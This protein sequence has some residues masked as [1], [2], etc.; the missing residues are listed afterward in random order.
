MYRII[1]NTDGVLFKI[2][3][4]N[5]D[6]VREL[7]KTDD[8]KQKLNEWDET[9]KDIKEKKISK[10]TKKEEK[11][12]KSTELNNQSIQKETTY[13]PSFAK[14]I[15]DNFEV[16]NFNIT[17][18]GQFCEYDICKHSVVTK[19]LLEHTFTSETLAEYIKELEK[20]QE[21]IK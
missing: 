7:V 6:K 20:I 5:L 8:L 11:N 14:K 13:N 15:P 18:K 16:L 9:F 4:D 3:R 10:E 12:M 21:M 2:R 17:L 1:A 19:N